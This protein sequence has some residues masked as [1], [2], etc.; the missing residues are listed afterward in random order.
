MNERWLEAFSRRRRPPHVEVMLVDARRWAKPKRDAALVTWRRRVENETLSVV[1]A[2]EL[3][4][5]AP[6]D[7]ASGAAVDVA[8]ARLEAD[9]LAHVCL[10][11]GVVAQLDHA[12]LRDLPP[13]DG[14][15][16]TSPLEPP[17]IRFARLVLTGL[18]VCESVSAARFEDVLA[19]TDLPPFDRA[20]AL[21]LRDEKAHA[22]LGFA[23]LPLAIERL[24]RSIGE[25][26]AARLV[27][28]EL[29]ETFAH[30]DRLVG[31]DLERRGPLPAPGRQPRRNP[32]VV[33]PLVDAR[34][35]YRAI[36]RRVLPRLE[37][38]GVPA[39]VAWSGRH[40]GV[41]SRTQA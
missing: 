17:E 36:A 16:R 33:E 35:F 29:R 1:V 8:L 6:R 26:A 21:F 18:A 10:A 14:E 38:L 24:R 15:P 28:A 25:E 40:G 20:I 32:G 31:L 7:L 4:E 12:S 5:V 9:E 22:E 37:R 30:L 34:A 27:D 3:R 23:L 13:P 2:R 39:R 19:A 11:W 41:S